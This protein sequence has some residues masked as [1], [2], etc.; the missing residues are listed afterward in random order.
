MG[1]SDKRSSGGGPAEER[2]ERKDMLAQDDQARK[3][4]IEE[5]QAL[6]TGVKWVWSRDRTKVRPR[7]GK[8][9][10]HVKDTEYDGGRGWVTELKDL[11]GY[12]S[13]GGDGLYRS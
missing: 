13:R 1:P 12:W 4:E 5:G 7:N 2:R 6:L 10:Y 9:W 8:K 3:D 11:G